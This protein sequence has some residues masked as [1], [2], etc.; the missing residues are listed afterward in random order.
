LATA[1]VNKYGI[2]FSGL[3]QLHVQGLGVD[4]EGLNGELLFVLEKKSITSTDR[5]IWELKPGAFI[6]EEIMLIL[7]KYGFEVIRG[8]DNCDANIQPLD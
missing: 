7:E 8:S 3:A 5:A 6:P 2:A 4:W 1:I